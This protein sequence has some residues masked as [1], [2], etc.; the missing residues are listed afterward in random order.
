MNSHLSKHGDGVK[1]VA[2]DDT[3]EIFKV[4]IKLI[5]I[6]FLFY[7]LCSKRLKMAQKSSKSHGLKKMKMARL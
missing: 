6:R 2:F 5:F 3:M 1:D 7:F 4:K